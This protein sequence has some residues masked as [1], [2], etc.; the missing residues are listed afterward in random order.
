MTIFIFLWPIRVDNK[1]RDSFKQLSRLLNSLSNAKDSSCPLKRVGP[2]F[3]ELLEW[4]SDTPTPEL[5]SLS[6]LT[7]KFLKFSMLKWSM[8]VTF[9]LLL[10]DC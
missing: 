5:E 3:Q 4:S 8:F 7:D 9:L 10:L 2:V 1:A 6:L